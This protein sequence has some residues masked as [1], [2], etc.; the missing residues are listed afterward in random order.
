MKRIFFVLICV[1]WSP[2]FASI[3]V[4]ISDPN[5]LEVMDMTE[6]MVGTQLSLVVHSD[7]NDFWSGGLFIEGQDRA[8][9]QLSGRDKDPNSRDWSGSHLESAGELASVIE[10][11]DSYIRGF[12][13]YA[14]DFE[15][16]PNDWFVIDYNAIDEGLCDIILYDHEYSFTIPDPNVSI[17][18]LNTP[19]RDLYADGFV[20]YADFAIFSGYWLDDGCSDPNADCYKADFSRDGNVG[21]EDIVMFADFWLYGN[22][23]WK[24][25]KEPNPSKQNVAEPNIIY[26]VT[27]EI[28]DANSHSEITLEVGESI[29]LYITKNSLDEDV[30]V[31]DMDVVVSDPNLGWIDNTPDDPETTIVEGTAQLLA[32]PRISPFDYYGPS[33]EPNS[34]QLFAASIG[35]PMQDGDMASFIY[36]ATEPNDITLNLVNCGNGANL[37]T[38][39]IHQIE[40]VVEMLQNAYEES[41]EL[42]EA[43]SES[44]WNE[45][46]EDV[47][48]SQ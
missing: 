3:Q 14:D 15:R 23:G 29:T 21:L 33:Q 5:T 48:Q 2:V 27:Y 41:E 45:F 18:F 19:T 7:S 10:W 11:K 8:I 9:G 43:V 22:P 30:Y 4:R 24:P 12:D 28:V 47:E 13:M 34:I 26:D 20:N 40:S 16:E 44:K 38:I 42:Q 32:Y 1:L 46:I 25:A 36:T 35:S 6:V 39:T 31:F 37:K 17:S